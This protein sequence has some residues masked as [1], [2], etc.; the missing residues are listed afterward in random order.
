MAGIPWT[1]N[2]CGAWSWLRLGVF[3][4]DDQ[5]VSDCKFIPLGH[6]LPW[7]LIHLLSQ[8]FLWIMHVFRP[9]AINWTCWQVRLGVTGASKVSV[10]W[11]L[12]NPAVWDVK[13]VAV[14]SLLEWLSRFTHI[15]ETTPPTHYHINDIACLTWCMYSGGEAFSYYILLTSTF[16]VFSMGQVLQRPCSTAQEV[17]RCI[18]FMRCQSCMYK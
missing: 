1:H 11:W 15:L 7:V 12:L 17:A 4:Q 18:T 9:Q 6:N 5:G 10:H 8:F 2:H 14:H 3:W 13:S 16:A